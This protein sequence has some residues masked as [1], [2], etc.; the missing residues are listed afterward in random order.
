MTASSNPFIRNGLRM[1]GA[2]WL[3]VMTV[4]VY[5]YS[6]LLIGCLTVP[7]MT[8]PIETLEDVAAS[9]EVVLRINPKE[10]SGLG[11]AV[12]ASRT[13]V[14]MLYILYSK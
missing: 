4:M 8:K 9:T 7:L 2:L 1:F 11:K 6:G 13:I 3:L 12:M 14:F 10:L 5:A